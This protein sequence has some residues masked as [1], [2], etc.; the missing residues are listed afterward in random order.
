MTLAAVARPRSVGVRRPP[1][2]HARARRERGWNTFTVADA[3]TDRECE[4]VCSLGRR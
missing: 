4:G 1:Q 3:R 2:K